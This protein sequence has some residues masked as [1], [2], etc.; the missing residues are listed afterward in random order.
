MLHIGGVNP[1]NREIGFRIGADELR[2]I[3]ARIVKGH[4]QLMRAGHD[5]T[6]GE[7]ETIARDD[8]PGTAA[9]AALAADNANVYNAWG[10][11]IH[12]RGNR[13]RIRIEELIIAGPGGLRNWRHGGRFVFLFGY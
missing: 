1:N 9:R 6:V 12:D 7:N 11:A 8:K 5:M 10:H 4:V 2:W 3:N 13:L